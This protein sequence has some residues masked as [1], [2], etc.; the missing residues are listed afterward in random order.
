M[1]ISRSDLLFHAQL[2]A[3][4]DLTITPV[5]NR[6]PSLK[7]C[8]ENPFAEPLNLSIP[9]L[10]R[11]M[12]S[13]VSNSTNSSNKVSKQSTSSQ[14]SRLSIAKISNSIGSK[15]PRMIFT[16]EQEEQL[17]VFVRDT[18]NYYSGLSSKEL[19][20]LAFVFGVCNQVEMPPGW[21]EHHQASLEWCIAFIKRVKLPPTMITGIT[22]KD[23]PKTVLPSLQIQ[24]N[25]I[26]QAK[27]ESSNAV[28]SIPIEID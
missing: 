19:R 15:K 20:I 3:T 13:T 16:M 2:A 14:D 8:V 24:Q 28:E 12:D 6:K 1:N 4:N 22:I 5:S 18:S 10:Q 9:S 27:N 11:T 21:L 26:S 25:G 7:K 17:A 23:K